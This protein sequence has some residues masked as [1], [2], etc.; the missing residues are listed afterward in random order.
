MGIK[1]TPQDRWIMPATLPASIEQITL[2]DKNGNRR[3]RPNGHKT[4]GV[5]CSL[6]C[7]DHL[8]D[9]T[10]GLVGS[11]RGSGWGWGRREGI[12]RRHVTPPTSLK[13]RWIWPGWQLRR[14]CSPR[15]ELPTESSCPKKEMGSLRRIPRR[16]L[17]PGTRDE[18]RNRKKE[19][20][21]VFPQALGLG[22]R[23]LWLTIKGVDSSCIER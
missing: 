21:K 16:R 1:H 7:V 11:G 9:D 22:L 13:G 20:G 14:I 5:G 12:D 18:K 10:C 19:N 23:E 4:E 8:A 15:K 6:E 17:T 2:D 3:S